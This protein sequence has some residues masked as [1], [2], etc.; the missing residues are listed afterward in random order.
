MRI[1][2]K[3]IFSQNY[4]QEYEISVEEGYKV[5]LDLIGEQRRV[6]DKG[7]RLYKQGML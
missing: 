1:I 2:Y 3:N 6:I 4:L 5:R 7:D